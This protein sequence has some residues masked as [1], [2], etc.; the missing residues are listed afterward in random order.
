M[1]SDRA[2]YAAQEMRRL[3]PLSS[4]ATTA[5]L[6]AVCEARG[7]QVVRSRELVAPG[8]YVPRPLPTIILRWDAG[9]RVLA[10]ELFH[11]LVDD[12]SDGC[13]VYCYPGETLNELEAAAERFASLLCGG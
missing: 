6:T 11:H 2:A 12:Q 1:L 9:A 8:V 10:H 7:V 5:E 3:Y 4:R 13:C